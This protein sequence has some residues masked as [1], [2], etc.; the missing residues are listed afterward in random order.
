M[1]T[2]LL[3]KIRLSAHALYTRGPP[4]GKMAMP[5]FRFR[6]RAVLPGAFAERRLLL[7]VRFV[8]AH[9]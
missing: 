9:G 4:L 6:N 3:R 7:F 8:F 5:S 2:R 1:R